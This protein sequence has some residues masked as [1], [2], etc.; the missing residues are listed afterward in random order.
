MP[1]EDECEKYDKNGI[2][3][4]DDQQVDEILKSR[5]EEFGITDDIVNADVIKWS[6]L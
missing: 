4:Y 2:N 3:Y 5:F 6:S 1:D